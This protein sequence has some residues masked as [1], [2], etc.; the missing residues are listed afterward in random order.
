MK[1]KFLAKFP[2]FFLPVFFIT[3]I[4]IVEMLQKI[5]ICPLENQV[6]ER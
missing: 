1:G 3:G 4:E 2:E 5:M 6:I